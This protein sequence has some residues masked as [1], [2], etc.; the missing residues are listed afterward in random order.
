M[1]SYEEPEIAEED[2]DK[3]EENFLL[4]NAIHYLINGA[5]A[6]GLS[7]DNKRAVRKRAAKLEVDKGQVYLKKKS[8]KVK[9]VTDYKEQWRILQSCHS[10]PSSG[11]F[12]MTKTW[13]RA[14]ERVYWR[15]MSNQA[16]ELVKIKS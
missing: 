2:C 3:Q 13:R 9:V 8:G 7:K 15:G 11:H 12:G 5:Y 14:A 10:E 16:K 6:E 4:D 1:A